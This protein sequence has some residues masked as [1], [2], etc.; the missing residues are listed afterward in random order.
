MDKKYSILIYGAGVIGSIY[1]VLLSNA[2]YNVT[3][4][5]RSNRL[6]IL[7]SQGLRYIDNHSIKKAFVKITERVDVN[8]IYDYIFVTV[9]Y[10]QI[11]T[12]LAELKSNIS[13]NIVTM[14]NNPNGYSSWENIIGIG[15]IIPAFAGAGGNHTSQW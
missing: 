6:Q 9:R 11:E 4:Y 1:A 15:R 2:G 8:D 7:K 5:A 14:V 10:E 12:A 13:N 3:V